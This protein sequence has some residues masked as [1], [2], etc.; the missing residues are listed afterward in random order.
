M[1]HPWGQ[2]IGRNTSLLADRRF[3]KLAEWSQWKYCPRQPQYYNVCMSCL[4]SHRKRH[5][6]T[7][8]TSLAEPCKH[9]HLSHMPGAV[10]AHLGIPQPKT[11]ELTRIVWRR[12]AQMLQRQIYI[13]IYIY[14]CSF[15]QLQSGMEIF[16]CVLFGQTLCSNVQ[17]CGTANLFVFSALPSDEENLVKG[18]SKMCNYFKNCWKVS[19]KMHVSLLL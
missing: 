5:K 19:V 15:W 6:I 7:A 1:S 14:S 4:K 8:S 9:C 2:I 18:H 10:V 11:A 16:H 17:Y 3:E 13:C 12:Q